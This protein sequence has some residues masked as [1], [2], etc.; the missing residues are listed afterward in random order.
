ML[1]ITDRGVHLLNPSSDATQLLVNVN[2]A[3]R[4]RNRLY[5]LTTISFAANAT[6]F[7]L[8]LAYSVVISVETQLPRATLSTDVRCILAKWR[9]IPHE[10]P[11]LLCF[12]HY[13]SIPFRCKGQRQRGPRRITL[14][15]AQPP[16]HLHPGFPNLD[17]TRHCP[18]PR[19]HFWRYLSFGPAARSVT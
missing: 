11:F 18:H 5:F 3:L 8:G 16:A 14:R 6:L 12:R 17:H 15:P 2:Q 9:P 4:S 19:F 10:T 13:V 1:T 7:S